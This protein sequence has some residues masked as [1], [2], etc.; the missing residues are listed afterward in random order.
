[1]N[2]LASY[3][4]SGNTWVRF[5]LSAFVQNGDLD[6]NNPYFVGADPNKSFLRLVSPIPIEELPKEAFMRLRMATLQQVAWLDRKNRM[7]YKT[8]GANVIAGGMPWMPHDLIET[9]IYLI[10]DPRDVVVSYAS[11]IGKDIDWSID[12]VMNEM[13]T[14]THESGTKGIGQPLTTWS[15]HAMTWLTDDLKKPKLCLRYEDLLS[16]TEEALEMMVKFLGY[17]EKKI[18]KKRIKASVNAC[19]FHKLKEQE[20]KYGFVENSKHQEKFFRK[21][22]SGGWADVLTQEQAKKIEDFHR[23]MMTQFRYLEE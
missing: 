23:D 5:L 20:D 3:P 6:I 21:G 8:H 14:W 7:L 16:H 2:I 1:M 13:T 17:P 12:N 11:H 18:T 4:K 10:R 9:V 15:N 22:K 19:K